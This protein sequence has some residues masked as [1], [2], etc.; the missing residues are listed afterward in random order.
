MMSTLTRLRWGILGCARISRRG[1]IPGIQESHTGVLNALASRQAAT[2]EA[3]ASEFQI[4]KAYKSYEEL[5]ADPEIDAVYIPLPNELHLTWTQAAADAGKHVL[6]EKPVAR[7]TE[8]AMAMA[9]HCKKRGVLLMEAFMWRYSPRI[10]SVRQRIQD[11]EIGTL[12][13]INVSFSF[14]IDPTDW[15]LDPERGGGALFDVGCYGVNAARFFT[16]REPDTVQAL[17]RRGPT[18]VDMTLAT[19]LGFTS[20]VIANIDCSFEL[21]YRNRLELVGTGGSIV[22]DDAFLPGLNPTA[23]L[24]RLGSDSGAAA[25]ETLQFDNRNQYSAMVDHFALSVQAKRLLAP[26]EDG[27]A[28]MTAIDA[29]FRAAVAC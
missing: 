15:R 27:V 20:G 11:G 22:L 16:Q 24:L 25:P 14:S 19:Q 1:L 21:P 12:R 28:Q 17:V 4:P 8:E 7:S 29:V 3:W 10:V 2:A 9:E 18:G 6:C 5:L 26:A 23:T 13:I